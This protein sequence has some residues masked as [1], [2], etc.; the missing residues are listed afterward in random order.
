VSSSESEL[1]DD[2]RADERLKD[3]GRDEGKLRLF[4]HFHMHHTVPTL[5]PH[6]RDDHVLRHHNLRMR[7]QDNSDLGFGKL[8][9]GFETPE[10]DSGILSGCENDQ[11]ILLDGVNFDHGANME[12]RMKASP[13]LFRAYGARTGRRDL[14]SRHHA[15]CGLTTT[16]PA[17]QGVP[18]SRD[19]PPPLCPLAL[20]VIRRGEHISRETV[21]R[22][23]AM[24]D[25]AATDHMFDVSPTQC[26]NFKPAKPGAAVIT[27]FGGNNVSISELVIFLAR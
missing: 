2:T 18:A 10:M 5:A 6:V 7:V 14:L 1:D 22:I 12:S 8:L 21:S 4:P 17:F 11:E 26:E 9:Y 27:C 19:I 24:I 20:A 25:T 15:R 23:N 16:A 13:L 3:F